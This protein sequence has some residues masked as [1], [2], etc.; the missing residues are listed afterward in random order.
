MSA[1]RFSPSRGDRPGATISGVAEPDARALSSAI[2]AA[3]DD[4]CQDLERYHAR[5]EQR[6]RLTRCISAADELIEDLE[7]LSVA[8]QREVPGA[9]QSRLDRFVDGLPAGVAGDLRCG[10][11]PARLLDQVF[12]IEERLFRLKLGEWA[13]AFQAAEAG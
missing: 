12:G 2:A 13:R 3:L 10:T 4:M 6:L 7:A 9:W 11:D 1:A 5:H 8:G